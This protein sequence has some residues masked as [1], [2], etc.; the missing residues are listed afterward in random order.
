MLCEATRHESRRFLVPDAHKQDLVLP[1]AKRLD[2]GIDSVADHP[3]NVRNTPADQ[4]IP[5]RSLS[6]VG[7][8]TI[9]ARLPN[10]ARLRFADGFL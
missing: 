2:D 4:R 6:V 7:S 1:F 5:S 9:K 3:K 8:P 10:D